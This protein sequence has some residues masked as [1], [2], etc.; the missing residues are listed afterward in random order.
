[1]PKELPQINSYEIRPDGYA[2]FRIPKT[3]LVFTHGEIK[4]AI[5]RG[6]IWRRH[7]GE[8][9]TNKPKFPTE[10]GDKNE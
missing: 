5:K 6:K 4:R 1:M 8:K 3:L 10:G 2:L 9:L 7:G